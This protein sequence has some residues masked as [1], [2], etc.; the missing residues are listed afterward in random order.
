MEKFLSL[1]D[2]KQNIIV[3]AALA[4]FGRNGY[5]KASVNDIAEAA[6]ISKSM[7]FYYFGSKKAMYLYLVHISANIIVGAIE[8][9]IYNSIEDFFDRIKT[10]T[11]IKIA[12][13]KKHPALLSFLQSVYYESDDEIK[14]ELNEILMGGESVWDRWMLNGTDI[15]KFKD[16]VDPKLLISFLLWA[17]EGFSNGLPKNAS[18]DD[19][20]GFLKDFYKCLDM[21][22]KYF[23]KEN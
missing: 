8:N 10:A 21:M 4:A 18:I 11:E 9:S 12:V 6:G 7:V 17:S 1:S 19:Y 20:D 5:K 13:L 23:Y 3:D 15:S 16:D 14:G 2:E 22:K